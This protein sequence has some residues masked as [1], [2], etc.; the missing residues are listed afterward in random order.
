MDFR[1][2]PI[3]ARAT[4]L[5][6]RNFRKGRGQV[7]SRRLNITKLDDADTAGGRRFPA[8]EKPSLPGYR[9]EGA[10]CGFLLSGYGYQTCFAGNLFLCTFSPLS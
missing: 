9:P 1:D 7:F 2:L 6:R 10:Q 4:G 3:R 5:T 8:A